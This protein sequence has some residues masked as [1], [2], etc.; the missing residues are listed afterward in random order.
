[1]NFS[2]LLSVYKKENPIYFRQALESIIKQ[3]ILPTEIVVVKDGELT[4]DLERICNQFLEKYDKLFRVI[5]LKQNV[6]LGMALQIGVQ[7]CKYDIIA[8]MDTDDIAKPE[9][10]AIQLKEFEQDEE[11]AIIGSSIEEFSTTIDN[12]ESIRSV[13]LSH[14][15]IKKY[16]KK[17]NPFNHMT[18]MFRKNAVLDVGNYQSIHLSEDYYLWYR[19]LNKGYKAKNLPQSLVYARVNRNTFQRRGGIKYFLHELKLQRIFYENHFISLYE[20]IQNIFIRAIVRIIPN[21]LRGYFYRRY[22][23]K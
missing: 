8:R 3:S 19:L 1:M 10:F 4:A 2:V 17:R 16:A 13:P 11:L 15:K 5:P 9:R 22:M 20:F 21:E 12:I 18:V 23:R 7:E 14:E 6:G